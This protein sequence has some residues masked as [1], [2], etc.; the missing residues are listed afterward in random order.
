MQHSESIA[1]LAA[2]MVKAQKEM[3][4]ASKDAKNPHFKSSFASLPSVIDATRPVLNAHGLAVIQLP[5]FEDGALT[6][7][8][9]LTHE[10]GEWLSG[11]SGSPLQKQDPQGI[12]SA[13]TYLRR[14]SLAALTAIGQEDDDAEGACRGP[15]PEV[16]RLT[17][18]LVALYDEHEEAMPMDVQ[19]ATN[20]AISSGNIDRLKKGIAYIK[21]NV[22]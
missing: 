21:E 13:I 10:S 8:T 19:K 22:Q 14:Y 5:G 7:E 6:M 18:E 9:I 1:K 2:A 11:V 3:Q 20:A 15:S 17:S 12:G 16:K 4:N